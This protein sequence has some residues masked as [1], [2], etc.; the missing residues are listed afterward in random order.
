MTTPALENLARTRARR[1]QQR[2]V[3][4]LTLVCIAVTLAEGSRRRPAD[5]TRPIVL[6][7]EMPFAP[8]QTP[9]L[10]VATFNIHSGRG[11]DRRLDLQRTA[12]VFPFPPDLVGLNEVRGTFHRRLGPD[13]AQELGT[14]LGMKSAFIPTEVRWWHDHFGNALL[15]RHPVTSLQRIPLAGTRDKAF[16]TALL[17]RVPWQDSTIQVL[18]VHVDS[19][20]DRARQLD[21]VVALFLGL[22]PPAILMGDLNSNRDDPVLQRLVARPDV[23]ETLDKSVR[24]GRGRQPIDWILA[25]GLHCRTAK[26]VDTDASDHP[27]VVAEF[28]VPQTP[29]D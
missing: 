24:D 26:L 29:V 2:T 20:D 25:R 18:A 10:R 3:V 11:T 4:L 15:T 8:Q 9:P 13:Q 7:G 1:R 5:P 23:V 6:R 21:A 28:D 16:R 19:Q 27:A 17:A 12:A 22:E 14:R